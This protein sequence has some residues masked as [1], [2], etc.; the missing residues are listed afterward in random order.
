VIRFV[1]E[2]IEEDLEGVVER[3]KG[4]LPH[5]PAPSPEREGE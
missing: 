2:E 4:F 1:N 3:I 5:P